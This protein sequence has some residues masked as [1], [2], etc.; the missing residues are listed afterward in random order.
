MA[1]IAFIPTFF[2]VIFVLK[3]CQCDLFHLLVAFLLMNDHIFFLMNHILNIIQMNISLRFLISDVFYEFGLHFLCFVVCFIH[4]LVLF[5]YKFL[6]FLCFLELFLHVELSQVINDLVVLY[7][8]N[9]V[10]KNLSFNI[11]LLELQFHIL[12]TCTQILYFYLSSTF[13]RLKVIL[14]SC[15]LIMFNL[16][17]INSLLGVLS[18]FADVIVSFSDKD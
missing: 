1:E 9:H 8:L 11:C 15:Q 16:K 6:E 18:V 13:G 17:F 12:E 4:F 5:L 14:I 3:C 7:S 10:R 2:F